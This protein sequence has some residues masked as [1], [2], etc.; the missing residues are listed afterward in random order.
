MTITTLYVE[1]PAA[2]EPVTR[3]M[4]SRL[5]LPV[6]TVASSNEVY[7][8]VAGTDDPVRRGKEVL[9]LTRNKGAFIKPCP[10]TGHYTCCGYQ[11]LHIGSF[12]SMDCAYCILQAYFHPPVLQYFV[13]HADMI[14]EL[15]RV[16]GYPRV[17]R[18]GTGEFTDSLIWEPWT[19]LS[20][21]LIPRFGRQDR[22]VLELKTKTAHVAA[23]KALSH[24]R[25]TI[26]AWS[27]NTERVI[28]NEERGTS[29]LEA[30]L[31]ASA[32]SAASGYPL[33]FHFDPIIIYEGCEPD[34]RNVLQRLFA[35]VRP[36]QIVWISLGTFRFMPGLKPIVQ[37]RFPQS[38]LVYGEFITGLDGK[39]RYFKPLRMKLYREMAAAIHEHAPE[40]CVY[41][42]MEDD[43]VWQDA[44]G[45][46]PADRGG[47]ARMLDEAAVLH[48]RLKGSL[49]TT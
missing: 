19:D 33:A 13:N 17:Q 36:E 49:T 20:R 25:K 26:L 29:S 6:R 34:Y 2:D 4:M 28:R 18:I 9:Y 27:L 41:L 1:A 5:R 42:C 3:A 12:C 22:A 46:R 35:A 11:I 32:E 21:Q 30:R 24:N 37:K 48:C 31:R 44:L 10:G 43:E 7:A 40:V 15:D 45:F 14:Q 47:L 16:F 39:M 23:L 38:K 8:A